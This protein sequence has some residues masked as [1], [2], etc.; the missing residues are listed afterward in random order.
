MTKSEDVRLSFK[1]YSKLTCENQERE[2]F[3]SDLL[4]RTLEIWQD[5]TVRKNRYIFTLPDPPQTG[6][7]GYEKQG[8]L[9]YAFTF[10]NCKKLYRSRNPQGK[11]VD[12]QDDSAGVLRRYV[13]RLCGDCVYNSVQHHRLGIGGK[14]GRRYGVSGR[15][16]YGTGGGQ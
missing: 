12:F 15:H 10:G 6:G 5:D 13:Y 9:G 4:A 7:D 14:A 1:H 11:S 8:G 3:F 2:I 16:G